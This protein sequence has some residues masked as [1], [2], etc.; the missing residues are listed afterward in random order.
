MF[1]RFV[2]LHTDRKQGDSWAR[3]RECPLS[4]SSDLR[5]SAWSFRS[6]PARTGQT[7]PS[8]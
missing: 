1:E 8:P 5:R 3:L 6:S 7:H 4:F 2:T